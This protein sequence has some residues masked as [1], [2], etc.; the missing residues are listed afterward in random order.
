MQKN[1]PCLTRERLNAEKLAF[2][3]VSEE[4]STA[5]HKDAFTAQRWNT[6]HLQ[7]S[8]CSNQ[9]PALRF[10]P[11]CQSQNNMHLGKVEKRKRGER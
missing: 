11:V 3:Q 4:Y 1:K 9:T 6:P 8:V 10:Q 2:I 5:G 7:T